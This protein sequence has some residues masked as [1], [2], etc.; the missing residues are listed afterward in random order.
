MPCRA[1]SF[2]CSSDPVGARGALSRDATAGVRMGDAVG[3]VRK[4]CFMPITFFDSDT[5]PRD[6]RALHYGC[7]MR[8]RS[9][10]S[11]AGAGGAGGCAACASPPT[12]GKPKQYKLPSFDPT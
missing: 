1:P 7:C 5:M 2:P 9:G 4:S 6:R 10:L 8:V 3:E 12:L 11:V